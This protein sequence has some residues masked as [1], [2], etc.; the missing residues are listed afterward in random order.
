MPTVRA[1]CNNAKHREVS[2]GDGVEWNGVATTPADRLVEC[3]GGAA[4][5]GI[6][7]FGIAFFVLPASMLI[8]IRQVFRVCHSLI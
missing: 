2:L 3:R 6:V 1:N 5:V 7:Y 4:D 8:L